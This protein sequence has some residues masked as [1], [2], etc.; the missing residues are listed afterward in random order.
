MLFGNEFVLLIR[1]WCSVCDVVW[2]VLGVWFRLR[3][4][5]FGYSD[6]SVLNCLVIMSGVWFGSMML[7]ELIWIVC[8]VFVMW[9]IM[10]VVVVFVIFGML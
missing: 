9:L 10:M 5:C 4:M 1:L 7:F 3:L 2:L 6:V 8:V